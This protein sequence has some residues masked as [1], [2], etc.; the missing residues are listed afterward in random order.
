[1]GSSLSVTNRGVTTSYSRSVSGT[2][3]TMTITNALSQVA[4]VVSDLN[5]SRPTSITDAN[6]HTTN[7]QYDTY[8]RL[9]R[10]TAPEG[11][12]VQYTLDARGNV[13]QTDLVPKP[14][15]SLSTITTT[16]A[17]PSSCTAN[18]ACNRPTSV[19]DGRGKTTTY[20]WDTTTGQLNSITYQAPTTGAVAPQKRFTYSV[21]ADGVSQAVAVSECQTASSCAGT[22]DEV[23]TTLAYDANGN[24]TSKT[25]ATGDGSL[26]A[27]TAMTYDAVA[28]LL[29]VDGPLAGSADTTR[30]RYNASRQVVGVVSPDPDGSGSLKN[31]AVRN[32]YV[33]GLLTKVEQGTVNSQSDSDWAGFTALQESDTSYDANAR[34]VTQ[35]IVSGSTTYSLIQA[36]YD[37]LGR[38]QCVA[39]RMSPSYFASLP[40]DACT[41]GTEQTSPDYGPDR[42]VKTTYGSAG[43]VTKVTSAYGTSAVSDEVTTAYT[44]NGEV[45]SVTDAEGNKTSYVYDGFDRL[46]QAL[47]PSSTKGAGTSNSSDYEQF[48]YDANGNVTSRRLR[49][50]TSI[51]FTFDALNRMTYKDLPG[52]EPDVT[53]AYDLLNRMTSAATSAQTLS[54]TYDGLGRN[55]T[56][57]G[58]QGTVTSAWD[59]AGRRTRITHPDGYYVDQDYLVTGEL[60]KIRENGATSGAGVLATYAYD[61]LGRRTS[62]TLGDG[63]STSYGYDNVSRLTS[64]GHDLS[65]T[66]YDQTL[67]FSYNPAAQLVGN[68]RSNDSYAWTGH[69]NVNRG[70]TANGLNQY[71]ASGSVTPTYDSRGNLTSAGSTTY[72]YS[73][74]NLLTSAS[75]GITLAYDPAMRLYETAGGT[76]GTTRFAYDGSD[77]I[78]EYNSSNS[79][80]RRY[81]H[82]PGTDEPLVWYEGSGTSD[83][84][85]LHS[86]ERGSVVS[87]GASSGTSVNTYD[88]YG[89]PRSSNTGRFQYT[90]QTW[91]PELGMYYYKARIYSPTMGRFMQTDPI[92]YGD[93]LNLYGYVGADP[94][95]R[96][97]P[98]GLRTFC[99]MEDASHSEGDVWVVTGVKR[100]ADANDDGVGSTSFMPNLLLAGSG[101]I[102][103]PMPAPV[104]DPLCNNQGAVAFVK[105][106]QSDAAKVAASLKVPTELILGLSAAESQWGTGRIASS[107]NN[108]FSQHGSNQP[109]SN[110]S[111]PSLKDGTVA[112]YA[113]YYDA[114]RG[115]AAK[116]GSAVQGITNP[117]AFA[118]ALVNAGFNSGNSKTGGRD[119][120]VPYTAGV[121][122]STKRR[123]RC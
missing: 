89:I 12:Y 96:I 26:S 19:T 79:L 105:A 46:Y 114:A 27:I 29:T 55:L 4:T 13:T 48:G 62:L 111:A 102:T 107:F 122:D 47:Y 57:V 25:V 1:M 22:A 58:P 104:K 118:Q 32:T 110:G 7:Y 40:S 37:A 38:P 66:A 44:N 63:S 87:I 50:G 93:G 72:G 75:G 121:I 78:G 99:W 9:T 35:S 77:L 81:V 100:C 31:R 119:D 109:F 15:S 21:G 71:T 61:D 91:L 24:V 2:T 39:T 6:G 116:Y 86:D 16:A 65:G 98:S 84:R 95:N 45:A 106:H 23:K 51:G 113:S 30:V 70:Y 97:D 18:V 17:F 74:E 33:N 5:V 83:R 41:L 42:I 85:F 68:T 112:T 90:G 69:Y 59:A 82:G 103:T 76:P 73:S 115:F 43:E 94:V 49:D 80:Q 36:S 117:T 14:G 53:Y 64:L 54:F 120:F 11:N 10:I 108:F 20:D 34:A 88:E 8:G 3:A 67:G 92:H 123:M 28:N 101:F 60:Q 56:Q 52:T